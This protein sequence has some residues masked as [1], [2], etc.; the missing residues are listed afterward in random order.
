MTAANT[1]RQAAR[2]AM[3]KPRMTVKPFSTPANDRRPKPLPVNLDYAALRLWRRMRYL[4]LK[5]LAAVLGIRSWITIQRW[6]LGR[7]SVPPYL[8]LALERLDEIMIWHP[9]G[10]RP[11]PN[12]TFILEIAPPNTRLA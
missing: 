10:A 5:D 4:T 8:Q 11:K 6:E 9:D 12:E 3:R 2:P 7:T 1:P